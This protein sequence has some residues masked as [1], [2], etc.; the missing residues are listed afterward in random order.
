M[1]IVISILGRSLSYVSTVGRKGI[2]P[3]T[4]GTTGEVFIVR[5]FITCGHAS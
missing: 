3:L 4:T 1:P 2:I 5:H